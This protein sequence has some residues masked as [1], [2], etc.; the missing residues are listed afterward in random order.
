MTSR[1][2]RLIKIILPRSRRLHGRRTYVGRSLLVEF[3]PAILAQRAFNLYF[4]SASVNS[5]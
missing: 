3:F 4:A 1:A 2:A 5:T